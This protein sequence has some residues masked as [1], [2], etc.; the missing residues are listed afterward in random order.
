MSR[1]VPY[2]QTVLFLA[3][4][5]L[6]PAGH[7]GSPIEVTWEDLVGSTEAFEDPFEALTESQLY[8]LS[9][10]A[11]INAMEQSEQG[12]VSDDF[13]AERQRA[14]EELESEGVDIEGLLSRRQEIAEK[15]A[16]RAYASNPDLDNRAVRIP[17]YLLPLEFADRDVTE[18]LLVPYVGACIHTPPPPPNQIVYVS[19]EGFP[20]PG[21]FQPVWVEGA[22]HVDPSTAKLFLVDGSSDIPT[23]Y[24]LEASSVE[25]YQPENAN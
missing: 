23:A 20:N 17:G 12:S 5:A 10:V 22:M 3:S 6:T 24:T 25:L 4:L 8:S 11:R 16:Q 15:R 18:F 13:A 14:V 1:I 9:I 2:L 19:S 21:R 7:A